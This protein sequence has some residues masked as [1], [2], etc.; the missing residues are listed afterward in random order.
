[1][2]ERQQRTQVEAELLGMCDGEEHSDIRRSLAVS[3]KEAEAVV[4]MKGIWNELSSYPTRVNTWYR[5]ETRERRC[6]DVIRLVPPSV[7]KTAE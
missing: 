1:M 6:T 2:V 7:A 3:S 4:W 5:G